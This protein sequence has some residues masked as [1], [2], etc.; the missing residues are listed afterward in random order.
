MY[1]YMYLYT[2]LF[3][4]L[5]KGKPTTATA[6]LELYDFIGRRPIICHNATFDSKFLIKEMSRIDKVIW[7]KFLCTLKLSRRLLLSAGS[8]KL[9]Q[10]KMYINYQSSSSHHDHRALSDV[11]VTVALWY[12]YMYI[13]I[14]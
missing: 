13:H 11:L 1:I 7:N 12:V 2:F 14:H 10:L 6:M 9:S 3:I 8:Y 4:Y 5:Y